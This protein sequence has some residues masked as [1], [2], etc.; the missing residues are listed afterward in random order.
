M[1]AVPPERESSAPKSVG[2][3]HTILAERESSAPESVG[4]THTMLRPGNR[5]D[6]DN[7][8]TKEQQGMLL[9]GD[10]GTVSPPS[11][12]SVRISGD[13][14]AKAAVMR[15]YYGGK[16]DKIH[17]GGFIPTDMSSRSNN[18]WNFMMGFLGVKSLLDVGCGVGVSS[19]YFLDRGARVLCVEGSH[20]AVQ[21]SLLPREMV[22]E[23]DYTRGPYWPDETFDAAWSVEFVEHVGRQ[24]QPNYFAAFRR[25]ALVFMSFS[26]NGGHHHVEIRPQWWWVAKMEA[27]GFVYSE[28]LS[29]VIRQ[30]ARQDSARDE[31][32]K[33][34]HALGQYIMNTMV[35]FINPK[36]ANRPEHQHLISGEGCQ[37]GQEQIPCDKRFKWFNKEVDQPPRN[38]QPLL[39]CKHAT[40][41]PDNGRR[42][43]PKVLQG[44]PWLCERNPLAFA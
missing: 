34:V 5:N 29:H 6:Y 40:P 28:E 26:L 10:V 8:R 42:R 2:S 32:G 20:D 11:K 37:W 18:T 33:P 23:H 30:N 13:E 4:T 22:V 31:R 41:E 21:H 25:C 43:D 1:R 27:A 39:N 19:R 17:L 35:V 7:S 24:F 38:H 9:D 15:K 14:E 16:G 3:T 12:P 44:G 36:V